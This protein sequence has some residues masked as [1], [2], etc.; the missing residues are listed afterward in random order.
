MIIKEQYGEAWRTV[1]MQLTKSQIVDN[2]LISVCE[3]RDQL[4]TADSELLRVCKWLIAALD[5]KLGKNT[6]S[7]PHG[8]AD[9]MRAAVAGATSAQHGLNRGNFTITSDMEDDML[10]KAEYEQA[11]SFIPSKRKRETHKYEIKTA[12]TH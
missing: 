11:A 9:D 6:I 1:V 4:K 5:D 10:L 7:I 8:I 2:L 3:D 12:K